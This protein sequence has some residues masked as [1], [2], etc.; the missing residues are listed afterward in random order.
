M[1]KIEVAAGHLMFKLPNGSNI[2][3]DC[4]G[5]P[6]ASQVASMQNETDRLVSCLKNARNI[7]ESEGYFYAKEINALLCELGK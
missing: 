2:S 4:I 5:E 6:Y 7:L 3:C 1:S